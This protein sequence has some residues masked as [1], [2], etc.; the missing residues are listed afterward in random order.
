MSAQS[1]PETAEA[2]NQLTG[3][4]KSLFAVAENYPN[5]KAN[6]TFL[7]LQNRISNLEGQIADRREFF[8]DSVNIYNIRINQFPDMFFASI[9]NFKEKSLYEISESDTKDVDI[10]IKIPK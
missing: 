1:V 2:N 3:A 9:L 10:K 7:Q 5:L 6:D 8:N 4:L